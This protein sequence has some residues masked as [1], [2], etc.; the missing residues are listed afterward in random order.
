[1]FHV[2]H[3]DAP[4]IVPRRNV[5]QVRHRQIETG[6]SG[7]GIESLGLLEI[8]DGDIPLGRVVSSYALADIFCALDRCT[9]AAAAAEPSGGFAS[10]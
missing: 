4:R 5:L 8:V 10:P 7:G 1:L 2:K 6:V 3:F 9:A